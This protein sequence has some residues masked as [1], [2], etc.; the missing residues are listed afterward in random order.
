[1]PTLQDAIVASD[2]IMTSLSHDFPNDRRNPY[3]FTIHQNPTTPHCWFVNF[4][5]R[6]IIGTRP[7]DKCSL[8]IGQISYPGAP[9][10]PDFVAIGVL[11]KNYRGIIV[12]YD[13]TNP[14]GPIFQS[15]HNMKTKIKIEVHRPI[16]IPNIIHQRTYNCSFH[17]KHM[18]QPIHGFYDIT[19][20]EIL[21]YL[22][23]ADARR[24]LPIII[25]NLGYVA[26][27]MQVSADG[28]YSDSDED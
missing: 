25:H 14:N 19:Q 17:T 24:E 6:P 26:R 4:P 12:D 23:V 7:R 10:Y 3:K 15:E 5:L 20:N 2:E 18:Q 21:L 8:H 22:K 9:G 27:K 28:T 1:M 16:F 11:I 13:L